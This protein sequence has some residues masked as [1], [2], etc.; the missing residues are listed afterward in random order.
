MCAR[1]ATELG[2]SD[3]ASGRSSCASVRG[4][5]RR[6]LRHA[7]VGIVGVVTRSIGIVGVVTRSIVVADVVV[8]RE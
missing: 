3:S 1:V 2:V 5:P 7:V 6:R 4:S 8:V